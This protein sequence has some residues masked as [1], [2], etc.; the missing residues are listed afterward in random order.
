MPHNFTRREVLA[1]LLGLPVAMAACSSGEKPHLPDGQI[2]GASD[3]VGHLVRDGFSVT[4]T[5]D[6]WER[7]K[8]VIVGGG[9]AGLTAAWRLAKEGFDDFV[10]IELEREPG[11][12]ARSGS[13]PLAS[14]PWGAHYL[15]VPMKE[16][17]PLISLLDEMGLLEGRSNDG[18]PIV[19]EQF[20]CHAPEER[21]FYKGSWYEGLYLHWGQ[22]REDTDQLKRFTDEVNRWVAWRDGKGRR[23]FAFPVINSSDDPQSTELD[24]ISMA[25]WLDQRGFISERLRWL[26]DY[27]CRDDYGLRLDQTSAG[28][29]LFYSA[30]RVKT[31][32]E[33]SQQ[34]ITWPEGNGRLAGHL[35]KSAQKNIRLGLAALEINPTD[36]NGRRGVDVIAIDSETKKAVGFHADQVILAAPHFLAKYLI[37]PYRESAPAHISEFEYGAWMVANVFLSERPKSRGFPLSWDNVIY[38]SPSL[39]YVVA[40]HQRGLDHGPTIFTYYYP[41]CDASPRE[42]R[43]KLLQAGWSDWADVVLTDLARAH[44]GIRSLVDRIDIMRWG[45]AMILPRP[46]FIWSA[47][48]REAVKPYRGIH[49]AHSDLS[50]M[51]LFEEAFYQ[52]MRAA[53]EVAEEV[54]K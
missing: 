21:T 34:F 48:R 14:Y 31:P 53:G 1:S 51:A 39:G 9:V 6:Q 7:K 24:K 20:L 27:G 25:E 44:P 15:P 54:K 36:P 46:G 12:T 47:A 43:S 3:G 42:S 19:A 13:S 38:E 37:R 10:L 28:A 49:F 4:P 5:A 52:G 16:N 23:A 17:V 30:S 45:H 22:E 26:I 35:Y 2:V 33:E 50:G 8:I 11:G 41:L 40:T 32:G 29:A 18:E